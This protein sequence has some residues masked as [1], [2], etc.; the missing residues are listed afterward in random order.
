MSA[1]LWLQ[2]LI[3]LLGALL[4]IIGIR[5]FYLSIVQRIHHPEQW[6]RLRQKGE[7]P[8]A[9]LGLEKHYKDKV[10]LYNIWFQIRRV[11]QESVSGDF[12]ELG[13]YKGDSAWL[14]HT[15]APGRKLHLFDTFS[16]F[17]EP[18]I[19]METGEAATYDWH[20]FADTDVEIVRQKLGGSKEIIFHEGHFP[21]TSIGQEHLRFAFVHI[22]A[23]LYLPVKA[24]LEYFYPRLTPGGVL[25]IHDYTHK[26]DG[27]CRA[28]DQFVK[29]IPENLIHVPDM[30]GS[31]M[32]IKNKDPH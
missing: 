7:I 27:L 10:R 6:I 16:G 32:I 11:N 24:G 18:D 31:V 28:V 22:D 9:V 15:L 2:Y 3:Y 13:V 26:W 25:I 4:L 12:A 1:E 21:E 19:S 29:H 14:I 23:D 8:D 17:F 20:N 5:Y 30:H